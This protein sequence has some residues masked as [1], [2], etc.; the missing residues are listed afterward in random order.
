MGA[1]QSFDKSYKL[2][3]ILVHNISE[4]VH[5]G[6]QS[7]RE[8]IGNDRREKIITFQSKAN[9]AVKIMRS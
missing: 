8:I 4:V 7:K 3:I 2:A 6:R 1:G 5:T 9:I